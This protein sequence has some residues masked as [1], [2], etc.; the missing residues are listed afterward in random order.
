MQSCVMGWCGDEN[1]D[2]SNP[3]FLLANSEAEKDNKE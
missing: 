2:A 3:K 1:L